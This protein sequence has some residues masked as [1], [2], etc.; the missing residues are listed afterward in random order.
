MT[1]KRDLR[2]LDI[3]SFSNKFENGIKDQV[4]LKVSGSARLPKLSSDEP[5]E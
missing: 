3:Y 5:R 1:V 2:I 4:M